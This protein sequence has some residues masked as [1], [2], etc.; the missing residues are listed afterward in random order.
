VDITERRRVE[1][2][3]RRSERK[4]RLLLESLNEGIWVLD[5]D[6][7][8][9]YVN[10]RMPEMLGYRPEEML[11]KHLFSFM[12][13]DGRK[14]AQ[15]KLEER[16][17]GVREDHD[18]E[19]LRKDGSRLYTRLATSPVTDE[20]GRYAGAIAGV[21]DITVRRRMEQALRRTR[22]RLERRVVRRTAELQR[23]NEA[24]RG[25][26][27]ERLQAEAEV[28]GTR[29]LLE[30]V[31]ASLNLAVAYLDT[32]LNFVRV[33]DAYARADGQEPDF[34]V[35]RNHFDL[36]PHPENEAIFREV[37]RTGRPYATYAKPFS[38][39]DHPERG[40]TYWDW[41]L[42]PVRDAAGRVTGI[43]LCL[44]DVT[45]QEKGKREL[46]SNQERLRSLAA[47]L[48]L[49]EERERRRIASDLHDGVGQALTVVGM[50]LGALKQQ[51]AGCDGAE[52]VDEIRRIVE[53]V[54]RAARSLAFD[55]SP[56][57]LY[58]LGLEA[59]LEWLAEQT[60]QR[61][62][63]PT[64]FRDDRRPKPLHEDMRILLYRAVRELL[65]NVAKH[66]SAS[67]ARLSVGR[68]DGWIRIEVWDDGVGFDV[69]RSTARDP[70]GGF[71]LFSI[72]ERLEHVGGRLEVVSRPGD[73]SRLVL[74]A[75]L[76]D[77]DEA[78]GDA[79]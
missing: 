63:I 41:T 15:Q 53:L 14:I 59:A 56:P 26:I 4:H 31:F 10:S 66:A 6:G 73:G 69:P 54:M 35:G 43:V 55:L 75:P 19:F 28:R 47:Q 62:G 29:D 40:V 1:E 60:E 65:V 50:K 44:M 16:A 7:Y 37:V 72:R 3:L 38:Y 21:I 51:L 45:E 78:G 57:V 46:E 23:A 48:S 34:F 11:G 58:E 70:G 49:V 52:T 12:D 24:L 18:F 36:Y 61:H 77:H 74:L 9:A 76:A 68:E 17:R 79:L 27:A 67:H 20:E 13:E 33:N 8:T 25:E 71:G 64:D 2:A 5:E 42:Q 30:Q 22:D 32:D 39:P